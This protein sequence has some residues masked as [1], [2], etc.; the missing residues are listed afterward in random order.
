MVSSEDVVSG[1]LCDRGVHAGAGASTPRP[2]SL[3]CRP[4]PP[5][6]AQAPPTEI[7][8]ATNG[9]FGENPEPHGPDAQPAIP[10]TGLDRGVDRL[11]ELLHHPNDRT[12]R[13]SGASVGF[14]ADRHEHAELAAHEPVTEFSGSHAHVFLGRGQFSCSLTFAV[15]PSVRTAYSFRRTD[16][17]VAQ[18][19]ADTDALALASRST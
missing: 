16:Q 5:P 9:C 7:T 12:A 6:P 4:D 13:R 8:S 17:V 18:A 2:G 14:T 10:C 19:L 3:R 1:G 15:E 11:C